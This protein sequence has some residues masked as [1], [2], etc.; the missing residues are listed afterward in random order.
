MPLKPTEM[1]LKGSIEAKPLQL[2]TLRSLMPS[3]Y[4][5]CMAMCGNGVKTTG[6]TATMEPLLMAV[7]GPLVAMTH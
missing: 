2:T 1:A 6:R 3:G 5:I 4:T 7:P